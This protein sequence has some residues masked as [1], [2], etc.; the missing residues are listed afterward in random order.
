VPKLCRGRGPAPLAGTGVRLSVETFAPVRKSHPC[1]I[2]G[3]RD[4]DD[5]DAVKVIF[6][7][8]RHEGRITAVCGEER[9]GYGFD[10][11]VLPGDDDNRVAIE[12]L[13]EGRSQPIGIGDPEARIDGQP[14]K[15]RR[16]SIVAR[17]RT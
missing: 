9:T 2:P 6:V 12:G 3:S 14:E 13:F 17:G 15:N 8:L 1:G 16:G 5:I 11:P 10:E 7:P 4:R